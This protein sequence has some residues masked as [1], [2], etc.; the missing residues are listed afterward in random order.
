MDAELVGTLPREVGILLIA[1]GIGGI[2]LPGPIGTPLSDPG[3]GDALSRACLP[4]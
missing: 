2:L 1:A 4:V 3:R